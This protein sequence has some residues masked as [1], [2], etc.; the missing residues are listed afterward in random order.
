LA[1][2]LNLCDAAGGARMEMIRGK[3]G[4]RG[5]AFVAASS[6]GTGGVE[7]V[8]NAVLLAGLSSTLDDLVLLGRKRA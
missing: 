3:D 5:L 4:Y 6:L 1:G 8:K 7:F 2:T